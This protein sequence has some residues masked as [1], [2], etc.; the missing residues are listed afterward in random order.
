MVLKG[1]SNVAQAGTTVTAPERRGNTFTKKTLLSKS[2]PESG[3][4]CLIFATH[5]TRDGWERIGRPKRGRDRAG[6]VQARVALWIAPCMDM[7][8]GRG[9]G[10]GDPPGSA[11]EYGGE[12]AVGQGCVITGLV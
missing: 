4:D 5:S 2:R 10:N 9:V 12:D 11:T 8:R 3:L 7:E 1:G 6:G